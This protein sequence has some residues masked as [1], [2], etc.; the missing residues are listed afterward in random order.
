LFRRELFRRE[1]AP[2]KQQWAKSH[3]HP[4]LTRIATADDDFN[5][6][7]QAAWHANPDHE[8]LLHLAS[9]PYTYTR[10]RVAEN[11]F[12]TKDAMDMLTTDPSYYVRS[13]L[14]WNRYVP[15]KTKL[16]ILL[17]NLVSN[18]KWVRRYSA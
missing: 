6:K 17:R 7:E 18:K 15:K 4:V 13:T 11:P 10:I 9:D 14:L 12:I 2:T 3:L 8:T 1:S 5:E 16:R